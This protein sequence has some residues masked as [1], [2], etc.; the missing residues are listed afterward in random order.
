MVSRG[1]FPRAST[2]VPEWR[3]IEEKDVKAHGTTTL[4]KAHYPLSH[5]SD[6][7]LLLTPSLGRASIAP[8][9][10]MDGRGYPSIIPLCSMSLFTSS[11]SSGSVQT[12]ICVGVPHRTQ[13]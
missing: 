1:G 10:R 13:T 8:Q 5:P 11:I 9:G 6:N 4:P 2:P 7:R 12:R 3:D